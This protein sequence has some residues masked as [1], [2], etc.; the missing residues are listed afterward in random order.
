MQ[1]AWEGIGVEGARQPVRCSW[2]GS[3]RESYPAI[4]NG[5]AAATLQCL[6][7]FNADTT[8]SYHERRLTAQ[9]HQCIKNL[10]AILEAAGTTLEK[11]VKVN[12]WLANM[13]DFAKM[14][15]VYSTYWGDVKP[16]RTYVFSS[17][18][19]FIVRDDWHADCCWS[20]GALP[21]RRCRSTPTSRL[22]ARLSCKRKK[23]VTR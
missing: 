17:L 13:E 14:N 3:G 8:S 11:V 9:Q 2:R 21:S 1:S 10:K 18:L 22:S 7:I 12:V 20:A 23:G 4:S 6:R 19:D 15:E 16:C 5:G